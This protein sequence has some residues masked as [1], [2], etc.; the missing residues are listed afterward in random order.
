ML[1]LATAWALHYHPLW[2]SP[3]NKV[4]K[5]VGVKRKQCAWNKNSVKK[6]NLANNAIEPTAFMYILGYLF[7]ICNNHLLLYLLGGEKIV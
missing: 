7:Y 6:V 4:K 1:G 3:A 5:T 2:N